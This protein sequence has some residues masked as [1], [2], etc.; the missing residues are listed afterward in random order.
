MVRCVRLCQSQA[1]C[2]VYFDVDTTAHHRGLS[3][4]LYIVHSRVDSLVDSYCGLYCRVVGF[5][6]GFFIVDSTAN[7]SLPFLSDSG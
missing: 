4:G 6:A 3:G 1:D 7:C 2:T 5:T